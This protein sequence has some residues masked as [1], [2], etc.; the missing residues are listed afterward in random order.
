MGLTWIEWIPSFLTIFTPIWGAILW[1]LPIKSRWSY[2]LSA[3][4]M[5]IPTV[6]WTFNPLK[7][8]GV[9]QWLHWYGLFFIIYIAAL[10]VKL[11]WTDWNKA[12]AIALIAL[13]IGGEMWE[14]PIFVYD[15]LGKIGVLNNYWTGSIL[16]EIWVFSH[17]RRLYTLAACYL[18]ATLAKVKMTRM[19]LIF[20]VA[21]MSFCF[22]LLLPIGLGFRIGFTFIRE[23]AHITSLG[24]TGII[25]LEGFHA[26]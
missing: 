2:P 25:I 15:Y 10:G 8:K 12:A 18:L 5:Y 6:L 24:F 17:V 19:G 1:Y 21:G 11:K 22:I 26:S 14:I 13:F 23:M 20:L 7:L 16:D 9:T 3:I 4:A